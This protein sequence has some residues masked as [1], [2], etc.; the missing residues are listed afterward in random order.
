MRWDFWDEI[1]ASP[2]WGISHNTGQIWTAEI[3]WINQIPANVSNHIRIAVVPAVSSG[4]PKCDLVF[5]G[6]PWCH[7]PRCR[8]PKK[9]GGTVPTESS[10]AGSDFC[11]KLPRTQYTFHAPLQL[12][13]LYHGSNTT[14]NV[15][16]VVVALNP[17]RAQRG[18][19][20]RATRAQKASK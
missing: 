1:F 13:I 6:I 16:E 10:Q 2:V 3:D 19:A 17:T 12:W 14:R 7:D 20:Q 8:Q 9:N 18:R 11:L 4:V 5:Q 15:S